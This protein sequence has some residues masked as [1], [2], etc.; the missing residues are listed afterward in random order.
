M[1]SVFILAIS[2]TVITSQFPVVVTYIFPS[3]KASSKVV[4]SNPSIAACKA[5]IGSIS[6]TK[7][8]APYPRILLAHPFPTSPYPQTTTTL[9]AIITSVA[10]LIPSAKDSLQPYRLSNLLFV[11]ESFTFIAGI[12]NS[13]LSII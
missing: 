3:F 10:R 1:A 9:P 11:T 12:N 13:P 8:L 5:Q 4:T 2:S 6:V 7:T